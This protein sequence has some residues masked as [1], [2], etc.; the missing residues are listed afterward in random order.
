MIKSDYRTITCMY[1]YTGSLWNMFFVPSF[2]YQTRSCSK[3]NFFSKIF[4]SLSSFSGGASPILMLRKI[5]VLTKFLEV[6]LA[7]STSSR[8][9][10]STFP[11]P[12]FNCSRSRKGSNC[13]TMK[14]CTL[15]RS[16]CANVS[17]DSKAGSIL[18][19]SP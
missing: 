7:A 18:V 6:I 8:S 15:I 17:V 4:F 16:G 11:S 14:N 12:V 19:G 3:G 13:H 1:T 10:S 5:W 9:V 2:L